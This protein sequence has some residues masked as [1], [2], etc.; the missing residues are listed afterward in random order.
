MLLKFHGVLQFK[1]RTIS[2]SNYSLLDSTDRAHFLLSSQ[3]RPMESMQSKG[4]PGYV[5]KP[6]LQLSFATNVYR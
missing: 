6:G 3:A 5:G 2:G 4:M 1:L